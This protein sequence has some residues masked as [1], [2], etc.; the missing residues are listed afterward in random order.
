LA[1]PTGEAKKER[2]RK[3]FD[4]WTRKIKGREKNWE[5]GILT[6]TFWKGRVG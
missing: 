6:E 3:S 1:F 4:D 5:R 2:R